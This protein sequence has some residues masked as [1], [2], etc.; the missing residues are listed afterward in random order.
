EQPAA[1]SGLER[2]RDEELRGTRATGRARGADQRS[3]LRNRQD[4]EHLG[5]ANRGMSE[6]LVVRRHRQGRWRDAEQHDVRQRWRVAEQRRPAGIWWRG[7]ALRPGFA[8]WRR[9]DL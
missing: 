8:R 9:R 6:R 7:A 4:S 1:I 5:V 2:P 3:D